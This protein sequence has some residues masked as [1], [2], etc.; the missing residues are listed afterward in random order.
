MSSEPSSSS[1][2]LPPTELIHLTYEGNFQLECTAKVV[3]SRLIDEVENDKNDGNRKVEI[4][5]DTTAM[6]PQGGGQPTDIGT[7][8]IT[9]DDCKDYVINVERVDIDRSSGIVT[10]KGTLSWLSDVKEEEKQ[11][12][13]HDSTNLLPFGAGSEVKVTVDPENRRI[14][15][16]CHTAGHVL[17]AAMARCGRI[18]P[19][20]KV[21]DC[22]FIF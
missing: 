3:S 11:A 4:I 15:S 8:S 12:V 21:S 6:H 7:I 18:M 16:E 22:V 20:T 1:T 9:G 10:H 13:D 19:P 5:L 2:A 14:V 17:D